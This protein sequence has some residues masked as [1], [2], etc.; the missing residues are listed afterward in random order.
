MSNSNTNTY[1]LLYFCDS[2]VGFINTLSKQEE[3]SQLITCISAVFTYKLDKS[4]GVVDYSS[5]PGVFSNG[6]L[7]DNHHITCLSYMK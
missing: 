4:T 1:I 5:S 3:C 7:D 2:K 6:T